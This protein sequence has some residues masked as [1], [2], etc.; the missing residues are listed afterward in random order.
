MIAILSIL[1]VTVDFKILR[2]KNKLK[3]ALKCVSLNI[4]FSKAIIAEVQ[5]QVGEAIPV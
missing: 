3:E 2:I 5:I 1:E 4:L